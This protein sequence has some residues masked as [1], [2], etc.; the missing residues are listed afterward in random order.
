MGK[1]RNFSGFKLYEGF[2]DGDIG[3]EKEVQESVIKFLTTLQANSFVLFMKIWN[4]HW[5]IVSPTF[6]PTHSFFNDLYDKFFE[7]I[8]AVAERIRQ[9]GGRPLGSLDAMIKNAE[10]KEFPED[11]TVPDEKEMY[12]KVLEDYESIIKDI[13]KFLAGDEEK[14]EKKKDEEKKVEEKL[15]VDSGT[16]NFLEDMIMKLE[17]DAWMLRSHLTK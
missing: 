3:I 14:E 6:G 13:R 16:T 2:D 7:N 9:L 15:S 4:F 10:L 12:K 5:N 17:K 11:D 1:I 8:D